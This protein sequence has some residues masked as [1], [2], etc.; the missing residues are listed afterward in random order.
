MFQDHTLDV[1]ILLLIVAVVA[2]IISSRHRRC[3]DQAERHLGVRAEQVVAADVGAPVIQE[4]QRQAS[5]QD[6][7]PVPELLE[8]KH[9]GLSG[10]PDYVLFED[11]Y[12]RPVE[13]KDRRA[14]E[15]RDS[16]IAQLRAYCLLLEDNG[17]PTNGGELRYQN[18]FFDIPYNKED[19][20]KLLQILW[21]MRHLMQAKTEQVPQNRGPQCR[22]CQ[23]RYNCNK[24]Q[25]RQGG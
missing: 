2:L 9:L 6:Y 5:R 23:Y 22:N 13:L 24:D 20:N 10:K 12:Y 1:F 11:G 21:D 15:A 4:A 7:R 18:G 17:F 19:E 14:S 16:E 3:S 25:S 8:S